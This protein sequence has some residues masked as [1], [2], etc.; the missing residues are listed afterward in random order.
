MKRFSYIV[1]ITL[2]TSFIFSCTTSNN[3]SKSKTP[4]PE[5]IDNRPNTSMYYIGIGS[6]KKNGLSPDA[7]KETARNSA[8]NSL[9][10]EISV[11]I[12]SNSVINTIERDSELSET[13]ERQIT[14]SSSKNLTGYELVDSW[15]AGD[16]YWVY[17]RLSKAEYQKQ[18]AI[19]KQAALEKAKL[20]YIQAIEYKTEGKLFDAVHSLVNGFADIAEYLAESTTVYIDSTQ[21]DLGTDIYREIINTFNDIEFKPT[22]NPINITSGIDISPEKLKMYIVNKHGKPVSN[23]PFSLSMTTAG[24]TKNKIISD[25]NGCFYLP[26][27]KIT[28]NDVVENLT[29]KLDMLSLSRI[30]QDIFIRTVIR[31]IPPPNHTIVF[32]INSP[33]IFLSSNEKSNNLIN[34]NDL[35]K[36]A[37]IQSMSDHKMRQ[38]SIKDS[39][40]FIVHIESNTEVGETSSYQEST[41]LQYTISV[42]DKNQRIVYRKEEKSIRGFGENQDIAIKNAYDEAKN[43]IMRKSFDEF[44]RAIQQ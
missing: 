3:M 15:D 39:A 6:S 5:W 32:T 43:R 27:N 10:S 4:K 16:I 9:S 30:T 37:F 44:Y 20:K 11:Q 25:Q 1:F 24:L 2:L 42:V 26:L 38:S 14:S 28:S 34:N 19:K 13:F 23:M 31:K 22:E 7:Y 12:S 8:L 41:N 18:K 21:T 33:L 36:T 35:L 29:I 17:Y 40:D